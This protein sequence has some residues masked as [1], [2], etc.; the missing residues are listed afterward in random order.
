MQKVFFKYP[1][2]RDFLPPPKG[3]NATYHQPPDWLITEEWF[4]V[5]KTW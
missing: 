3:K 2:A 5:D 4:D 1:E